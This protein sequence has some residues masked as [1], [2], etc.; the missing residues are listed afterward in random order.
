MVY[1]NTIKKKDVKFKRLQFV[2]KQSAIQLACV[3][4]FRL[5]MRLHAGYNR[6]EVFAHVRPREILEHELYPTS[7]PGYFRLLEKRPWYE[8]LTIG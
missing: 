4:T 5:K 2:C 7:Y 1:F 6:I 3:Q 8:L